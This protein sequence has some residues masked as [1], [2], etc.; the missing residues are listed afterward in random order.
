MVATTMATMPITAIAIA[1]TVVTGMKAPRQPR[2]K[3]A[4]SR[5]WKRLNRNRPAHQ[6]SHVH[7]VK[8]R[9]PAHRVRDRKAGHHVSK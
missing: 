9:R 7:L 4:K 5:H 6:G 3:S 1:A 8:V 2:R